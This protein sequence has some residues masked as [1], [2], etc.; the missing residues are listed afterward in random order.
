[1]TTDVVSSVS[2]RSGSVSAPDD[3]TLD[4]IISLMVLSLGSSQVNVVGEKEDRV[5]GPCGSSHRPHYHPRYA[6]VSTSCAD[7]LNPAAYRRHVYDLLQVYYIGILAFLT[8]EMTQKSKEK[9]YRQAYDRF[10]LE[11]ECIGKL[12]LPGYH[13]NW[14]KNYKTGG[15]YRQ[16]FRSGR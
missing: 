3:W 5:V 16:R 13:T 7:M 8:D 9:D 14:Y 1:M 11:I 15:E 2:G 12:T 10:H 6:R 4:D